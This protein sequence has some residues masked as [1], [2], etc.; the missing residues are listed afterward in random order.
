M[1]H[2]HPGRASGNAVAHD[3][4]VP[5]LP[6]PG[7]LRLIAVVMGGQSSK[8]RFRT[9]ANLLEW[10]FARFTRLHLVK[11]G[12]PLGAEV[13]I[14]HGSVSALHPIAATDAT[15]LLRKGEGADLKILL[16]L[17]AVISA[18]ISRHQVLGEMVVCNSQ[19]T[20]AIIPALS[21]WD[22]PK[23]YWVPARR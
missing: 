11:S 18:P 5:A 14:E 2:A 8:I 20:V 22:V 4:L 1:R 10:G 23:A 3:L 16:Q 13:R 12:E 21:P 6:T 9:A 7:P 19:R 17:P 15:V